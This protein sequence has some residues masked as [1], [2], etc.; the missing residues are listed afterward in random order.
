[1]KKILVTIALLI[2]LSAI[3]VY[4]EEPF[5][6]VK[7]QAACEQA[8]KEEKIIIIDFFTTWC[9]PCKQMD[10]TTWKDETVQSFLKEKIVALKI[11]AEKEIEL[12]KK[13]SIN[14]YPTILLIKANGT[15]IDRII[16]YHSAK[17]FLSEVQDSL[18]GKTAL[19]RAKEQLIGK[20]NDPSARFDYADTLAQV[21][22]NKEALDEYL[23]CYDHGLEYNK[24]FVGV[25][26]SFLLSAIMTLGQDYPPAI[27]ALKQRREL[28]EEQLFNGKGNAEQVDDV[29]SINRVLKDKARNIKAYDKF[30]EAKATEL[31]KKILRHVIEDLLVAHR[32][33]DILETVSDC[34]KLVEQK[35]K[36]YKS[37]EDFYQKNKD[38]EA[39]KH[40]LPII[41][42]LTITEAGNFYEALLGAKQQENA[43]KIEA[44][45]ISF[46]ST[47]ETFIELIKR[48]NRLGDKEKVRS[49]LEKA[50]KSLP[51]NEYKLVKE[52]DKS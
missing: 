15:E 37:L 45:I 23:W 14:A 25:R 52:T 3:R 40:S 9:G 18:A 19:V 16:G 38:S 24:D 28:A 47:K 49:L 26:L 46:S 5:R 6:D 1:M 20:E 4:A 13:Y 31:E 50:A 11:D 10:K 17:E 35:I 33:N 34:N 2:S 27:E 7:F 48:A 41:K 21:G 32:Y 36:N 42:R 39:G 44:Q 51:E 30:R 12:A 29:A 22:K 8:K 43:D